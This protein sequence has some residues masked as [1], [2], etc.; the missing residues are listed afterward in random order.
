MFPDSEIAKNFSCGK[1]SFM[2]KFGIAPYFVE[3]LKSQLTYILLRYL[4]NPLTVLEK[5]KQQQKT[6]TKGLA[7]STLGF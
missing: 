1:N 5:K 6:K 4:V 7:Y 3:L 2:V